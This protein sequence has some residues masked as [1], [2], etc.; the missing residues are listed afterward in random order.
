[1]RKITSRKKMN[2][3]DSPGWYLRLNVILP[4]LY[5]EKG[6]I[7]KNFICS[8]KSPFRNTNKYALLP[9][10][11]TATEFSS[12][13]YIKIKPFTYRRTTWACRH[14]GKITHP[15]NILMAKSTRVKTNR[16]NK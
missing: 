7:V 6:D 12:E 16:R 10:Y 8:S 2:Y 3:V 14:Y 11:R 1:M 15:V 5:G 13:E 4:G 9:I